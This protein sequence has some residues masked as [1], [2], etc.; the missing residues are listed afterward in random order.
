MEK[1]EEKTI[2]MELLI[3]LKT[4]TKRWMIAFFVVIA[5]WF[6]SVAGFVWYLSQYE[7]E[8]YNQDG[9]YNNINSGRQGDVNNGAP[10][11]SD[12]SEEESE[13]SEGKG[14]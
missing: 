10:I 14:N 3:E 9:G 4:Q 11:A 5:F 1:S 8:I 7:Y 6:I 12:S 2:A 13:Q